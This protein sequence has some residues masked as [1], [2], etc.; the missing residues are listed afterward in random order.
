MA[1]DSVEPLSTTHCFRCDQQSEDSFEVGHS[2]P[3]TG[4]Q[5]VTLDVHHVKYV[6]H[7][8]A[9]H[10]GNSTTPGHYRALL[11]KNRSGELHYGDDHVKPVLLNDVDTV[12]EDDY[13]VFLSK[14]TNM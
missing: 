3:V 14:D 1:G 2:N 7:A 11:R 10:L 6:V 8:Y 9:V 12:A 13:A 5:C 4:F